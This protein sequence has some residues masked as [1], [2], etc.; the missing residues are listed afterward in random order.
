MTHNPAHRVPDRCVLTRGYTSAPA[1]QAG[2]SYPWPQSFQH[3]CGWC[4]RAP[5][6][7]SRRCTRAVS[8]RDRAAHTGSRPPSPMRVASSLCL[9][10]TCRDL[11][12]PP[13]LAVAKKVAWTQRPLPGGG[14][15]N[16]PPKPSGSGLTPS[17]VAAAL[18]I[19]PPGRVGGQCSTTTATWSVR[20]A[21]RGSPLLPKDAEQLL[22]RLFVSSVVRRSTK[23]A[24]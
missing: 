24:R 4:S 2:C 11:G 23:S 3:P 12:L 9:S 18:R 19:L 13:G 15:G 1:L 17:K 22:A 14:D 20:G 10:V 21:C 7:A 6:S 5:H 8:K 16:T